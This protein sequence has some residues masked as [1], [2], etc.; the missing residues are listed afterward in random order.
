MPRRSVADQVEA[1]L[2]ANDWHFHKHPKR[3]GL[4]ETGFIAQGHPFDLIIHDLTEDEAVLFLV[5]HIVYVST[6]R[7]KEFA[8]LLC[9]LNYM[10]LLG[11]YDMDPADGEVRFK[12][13]LPTD[14][15]VITDE[16]ISHCIGA[17]ITTL[18]ETFSQISK[19]L[20]RKE[21]KRKSAR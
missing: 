11:A 16:Q 12:V 7:R 17:L 2:R 21:S 6:N 8:H 9:K 20:F 1:H 4:F 15:A 10:T 18:D 13:A 19:P 5:P 14:K 3:R